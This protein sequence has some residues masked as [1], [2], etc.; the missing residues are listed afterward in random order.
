MDYL[1]PPPARPT[2][3]PQP[4]PQPPPRAP[5]HAHST[6]TISDT[7]TFQGTHPI[8]IGVGS[9]IHPRA[10][11]YSFD[12]PITIG[13]ACIISEKCVLGLP[14]AQHSHVAAQIG[15]RNGQDHE[16]R[17]SASVTL[18]PGVTVFPGVTVCSAASVESLAVLRNGC[19]VGSHARVC[20]GCEVAADVR[21]PDWVVVWGGVGRPMQ[22]R[23]RARGKK[24]SPVVAA[25]AAAAAAASQGQDQDAVAAAATLEGKVIEEAR[26]VVL[27][28][29]RETLTKLVAAGNTRKK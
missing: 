28:R 18:A 8:S 5:V 22:R 12:G 10:K 3:Q 16:I 29:E 1:K 26:L 21:I 23:R 24:S 25:A 17:V 2:A 13:D 15:L 27:Q 6:A 14:P 7:A 11:L 4:R 9:I 20:A 19:V